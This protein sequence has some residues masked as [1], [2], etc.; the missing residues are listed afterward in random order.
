MDLIKRLETI[1]CNSIERFSFDGI[2]TFARIVN[3]HDPDTFTIIF[4]CNTQLIK[5]NVRLA[6]IDAPELTSKVLA[7]SSVC[8]AGIA[9]LKE[10]IGDKVIRV[11]LGKYDKYNRPLATIHTLEPIEDQLTCIN[12]YLIQ[13]QYVRSYDGGKKEPWSEEELA[14]AGTKR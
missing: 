8:K 2:D 10:L 7:E 11:M 13:Y 3:I 4:E 12:D 9:R 1:D 6:N 14:A 5:L